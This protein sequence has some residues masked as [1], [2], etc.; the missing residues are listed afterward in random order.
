MGTP[1]DF[2]SAAANGIAIRVIAATQRNAK[3]APNNV[4]VTKDPSITSVADLKGKRV[5]V[6]GLAGTSYASTTYLLKQAGV[7]PKNVKFVPTPFPNMG[8]QLDAG[9]LDAA[10]STVPFESGL[11]AKGYRPVV[12]APL[13]A[14]GEGSPNT[15]FATSPAFMKDHPQ[16]VAQF[17]AALSDAESYIA[18]NDADARK[19]LQTW[20]KLPAAVAESSPLPNWGTTPAVSV[21]QMQPMVKVI[22]S[23]GLVK[24][25]IPPVAGLVVAQ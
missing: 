4:L 10:V 20:L 23:S 19:I 3:A 22:E 1:M 11:V 24:G 16:V 13:A 2:F 17:R 14:L 9:R 6:V 15:M 18:T 7:D 8:D 5:G 21:A 25:K 12:D